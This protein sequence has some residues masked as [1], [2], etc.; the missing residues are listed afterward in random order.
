MILKLVGFCD[1]DW[2]SCL[3]TRKSITWYCVFLGKSLIS[4]KTKNQ[5]TISHS[6]ARAEYRAMASFTCE[7]TWLRYLLQDLQVTDLEAAKM[8]CDNQATMHIVANLVFHERT[9][10]M[11]LDCHLVRDK[12][13]F[14]DVQTIFH[15]FSSS[16]CKHV[17]QTFG[18]SFV[19]FPII[20]SWAFSISMLQLEGEC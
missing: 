17:H 4:W 15:L 5:T 8:H 10:H 6:L 19:F 3:T 2:A 14:E 7:F 20:A 9:K 18:E 12:I 13:Q 1:A 11:E 16:S